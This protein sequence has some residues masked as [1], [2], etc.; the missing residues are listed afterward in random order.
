M[1]PI[2]ANTWIWTSPLT[3][4]GLAD[5]APKLAAWGFDLA[6]LPVENARER[7]PEWDPA[8]AAEVLLEHGLGATVCAVMPPGRELVAADDETL[9]ATRD[10]LRSCVD[11]AATV[12]SGVV[13]GPLY[14]SVGRKWRAEEA[15]RRELVRELA[16]NLAPLAEY[17]G[18]RGVRLALE[19]LNRFETSF[20][21][22][23]AQALE[24][25]EAL[26]S[27][28]LGLLLD[29]FHAN[30]EE[31]SIPEAIRAAGDRLFHFHAC[32]NDRGSPGRDH[33]D[34]PPIA[35]ALGEAGYE[36]PVAIESFTAENETIATAAAIWR[37]LAPSQDALATDGLA[38]LH[39]LL[40][41]T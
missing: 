20:I 6:E 30:I 25:V 12:G 18:E 33:I 41:G 37:P 17:A 15:E 31:K 22:T 5:L 23:T 1:N 34:W 38:F 19:P 2:G 11:V 27:P 24:V 9:T 35:E 4:A 3:D 36:G 13:A 16:A 32:G 8:R 40:R 14:A 7:D 39:K 28:A 26:D 29:T 21:N 10:Y